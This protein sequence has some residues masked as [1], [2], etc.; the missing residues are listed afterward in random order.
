MGR[1]VRTGVL[2]SSSLS[3][4]GR[5]ESWKVEEVGV[6]VGPLDGPAGDGAELAREVTRELSPPLLAST[7]CTDLRKGE[8]GGG[9][10]DGQ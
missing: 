1:G 8:K 9:G 4:N 10:A 7:L 2:P 5:G 3:A 6:G